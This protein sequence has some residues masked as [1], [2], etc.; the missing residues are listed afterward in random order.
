MKEFIDCLFNDELTEAKELLVD[1]IEELIEEKISQLDIVVVEN[2]DE[3]NIQK[4]GRTKLI[5][6][7][8]RKGKIQRR[9]KKSAVKGFTVR[10]G[11]LVRMSPLERRH[12][13]M[14]ARRSKFKRRAK[15]RQTMRKRQMSIRKR[16]G[17]G[18]Q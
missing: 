9:I 14:A 4:M 13:K 11:Q 18:L 16:K 6:M 1:R 3:A 7:R 17:L 10:H 15:I 8:I 12:R 5:R 2:L